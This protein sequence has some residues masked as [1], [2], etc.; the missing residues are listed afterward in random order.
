MVIKGFKKT[1]F[2]DYPDKIASIVFTG[3]CNFK[4]SYC[5]N[6]ELTKLNYYNEKIDENYVLDYLSKKKKIIDGVVIT[7]G[8][9]TL[10]RGLKSFIKKIKDLGL[11]V[12]LDTNGYQPSIVRNLIEEELLDYIA[13]DLKNSFCKYS[14]TVGVEKIEIEKIKDSIEIIRSSGISY[15]FR[16]TL[17]KEF[18]DYEDI[19]EIKNIL[20]KD[21]VLFLQQYRWNEN[22]LSKEIYNFY[23]IDEME[24]FKNDIF[25][26]NG[27][28]NV[29]VRGKI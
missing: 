12:K 19:V 11:S 28:R 3:G 2:L 17:I 22:Q 15:E 23:T 6:G 7:G 18:H 5:H 4:C 20:C 14:S 9:P 27:Y 10:C 8:E 21:D 1:T 26:K 25:L 13:M 16:T 24:V 29:S